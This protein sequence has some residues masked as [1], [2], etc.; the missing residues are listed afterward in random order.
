MISSGVLSQ[1]FTDQPSAPCTSSRAAAPVFLSRSAS[2]REPDTERVDVGAARI[3]GTAVS[4]PSSPRYCRSAP[5]GA[6]SAMVPGPALGTPRT[7]KA[8]CA[9]VSPW[10]R[11]SEAERGGIPPF[12]FCPPSSQ[13]C[14]RRLTHAGPVTL[15]VVDATRHGMELFAPSGSRPASTKPKRCRY[16]WAWKSRMARFLQ[17]AGNTK[18]R[19]GNMEV[20]QS[21]RH[22]QTRN[23]LLSRFWEPCLFLYLTLQRPHMITTKG[24][25]FQRWVQGLSCSLQP[26][27]LDPE[28]L[29]SAH[30][31]PVLRYLPR[32]DCPAI[33][34]AA[35]QASGRSLPDH[36]ERGDGESFHI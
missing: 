31:S 5:R 1:L 26:A 11:Q 35:G 12:V 15:Y 2:C 9:W 25:R 22:R 10:Q 13:V 16:R 21:W 30:R 4:N 33:N 34:Q 20:Q 6:Q 7:E 19:T 27:R 24:Y 29:H 18:K 36:R 28:A 23:R 17:A 14:Q 32:C 8:P 3:P